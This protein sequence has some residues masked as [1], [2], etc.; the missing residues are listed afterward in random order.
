MNRMFNLSLIKPFRWGVIISASV[1]LV[2]LGDHDQIRCSVPLNKVA[3]DS[4][5]IVGLLRAS[6]PL[7]PRVK[8]IVTTVLCERV[9][10][11]QHGGGFGANELIIDRTLRF[12]P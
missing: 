6:M 10:R 5:T 1:W 11:C 4:T 7:H 12:A 3:C 9:L 8:P 2:L